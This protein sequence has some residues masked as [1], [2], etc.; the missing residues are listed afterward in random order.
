MALSVD[1]EPK[2]KRY[3]TYVVL[4][5]IFL[6]LLIIAV[7]VFGSAKDSVQANRK[8]KQLQDAFAQA[9]L[10]VPDQNQ[11][12]RVLGSDG[13]P[14]CQDPANALNQANLNAQL[15]NGAGGPG[16]RP[17]VVDKNVVQGEAL[18]ISI[19]CP[20]Q[21]PAFTN[22]VKGLKFDDVAG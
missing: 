15:S 8:A 11:I 10:A 2:R 6:I 18:A 7:L 22:Y 9:G 19:Y 21:L 12:V 13:G 20:E 3:I 14:I 4:G 5:G 16:A 1:L 17:T